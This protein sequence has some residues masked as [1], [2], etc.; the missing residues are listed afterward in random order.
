RGK[1]KQKQRESTGGPNAYVIRRYKLGDALIKTVEGLIRSGAISTTKAGLLL[2]NID[3][4]CAKL[5][6]Y[7]LTIFPFLLS[8]NFKKLLNFNFDK[9]FL[10]RLAEHNIQLLTLGLFKDSTKGIQHD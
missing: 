10:Q 7:S 8:D 2:D 6:F 5:S 4:D 3:P 1:E 9:T